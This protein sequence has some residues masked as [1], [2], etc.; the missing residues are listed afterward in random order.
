MKELLTM[1]RQR[2]QIEACEI[3]KRIRASSDPLTVLRDTK[4]A[5][6][7]L[8]SPVLSAS[9]LEI[10]AL[11]AEA[12]ANSPFAVPASPWTTVAGD[13]IVSDLISS[14]FQWDDAFL[15]PFIDADHLIEDM[16][17]RDIQASKYCSP[18]LVNAIC[19]FRSVG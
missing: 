19:A 15:C 1:L 13:G 12:V 11:E 10:Q 3:Y 5:D 9:D 7:L 14:F 16:R 8:P 6:L 18:L 2:P 4:A 17:S